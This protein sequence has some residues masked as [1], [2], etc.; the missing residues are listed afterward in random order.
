[1]S[2]QEIIE[3]FRTGLMLTHSTTAL[4]RRLRTWIDGVVFTLLFTACVLI[5][6]TKTNSPPMGLM[7]PLPPSLPQSVVQTVTD[8]DIARGYREVAETNCEASVYAM[9]EG[10]TP[11]FNWHK[12]GTFG[13]WAR[14]DLGDSASGRVLTLATLL[15]RLGRTTGRLRRFPCSTMGGFVRRLAMLRV[16]FAPWAFRCSPCRGRVGFGWGERRAR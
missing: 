7:V 6:G 9:P 11:S 2:L 4:L 3:S 10:I 12:R 14:L 16:R 1:M 8:E 13:E 5:G 15:F